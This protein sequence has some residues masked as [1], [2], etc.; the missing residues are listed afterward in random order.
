MPFAPF[1][2][3]HFSLAIVLFPPYHTHYYIG[4][5]IPFASFAVTFAVSSTWLHFERAR[6]RNGQ[7]RCVR[8]VAA[9]EHSLREYAS[10]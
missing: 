10:K 5:A 8:R 4:F 3:I 6:D 7:V 1:D 2:E 9:D